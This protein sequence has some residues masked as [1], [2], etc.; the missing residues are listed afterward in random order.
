[1]N[2]RQF[3]LPSDGETC[4]SAV[5]RTW[6][7]GGF[8]QSRLVEQLTAQKTIEAL[9]SGVPPYIGCLSRVLPKMHPWADAEVFLVNHTLFPYYMYFDDPATRLRLQKNMETQSA[10]GRE[11]LLSLGLIQGRARYCS[12]T[13]RYC[14]VCVSTDEESIGFAYFHREHQIPGVAV[15]WRH[16]CPLAC[17]CAVCGPYPLRGRPLSMAGR[18]FCP[19]VTPLSAFHDLPRTAG[20]LRWMAVESAYL[21]VNQPILP[22]SSRHQHLRILAL[23]HGYARGNRL[24][25]HAIAKALESRFGQDFLE[26]INY[27]AWTHGKPSAWIRTAF[28]ERRSRVSTI[29]TLLIIGL[30]CESVSQFELMANQENGALAVCNVDNADD[31]TTSTTLCATNQTGDSKEELEAALARNQYLIKPTRRQLGLSFSQISR[32]AILEKIRIPLSGY[33]IAKLGLSRLSQVRLALEGG[34]PQERVMDTFGIGW[35][36]LMRIELDAPG[37]FQANQAAR[38]DSI[39]KTAK[40][41]ILAL[42]D[43]NPGLTRRDIRILAP[44]IYHSILALDK[45][46]FQESVATRSEKMQIRSAPSRGSR[47]SDASISKRIEAASK[48]IRELALPTQVTKS[49]LLRRAG[50]LGRFAYRP[51]RFPITQCVLQQ[52]IESRDAFVERKIQRLEAEASIRS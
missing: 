11:I 2:F 14:P 16:D 19:R 12:G 15:C 45:K 22:T 50:A 18:C 52:N 8:I 32:Q 37:L 21:L 42:L 13:P 29:E 5:C 4:Y 20:V 27:P 39:R 49:A 7:R 51:D 17:G 30:V 24:C 6:E 25:F 43:K 36:A 28:R 41:R 9:I 48:Y 46:W 31:A 26:W 3:V 1:M 47:E 10:G 38:K 33:L 40:E 23:D 35:T 44:T 34:M